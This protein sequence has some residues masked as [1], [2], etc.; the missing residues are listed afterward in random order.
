MIKQGYCLQIKGSHWGDRGLVNEHSRDDNLYSVAL[1]LNNP[2]HVY[3]QGWLCRVLLL[4]FFRF[5]SNLIETATATSVLW[6]L[7]RAVKKGIFRESRKHLAS[8][9]AYRDAKV[10][11]AALYFQNMPTFFSPDN[12]INFLTLSSFLTIPCPPSLSQWWLKI[13]RRL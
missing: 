12:T 8:N 5:K 4:I 10:L 11:P 9:N 6:D 2:L 7:L 3:V 13:W 1:T